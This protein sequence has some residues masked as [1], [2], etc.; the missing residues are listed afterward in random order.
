[1]NRIVLSVFAG[2][3]LC[4][5]N[6]ASGLEL[7]V[8]DYGC[9]GDGVTDDTA[10]VQAALKA[11]VTA[12]GGTVY[13][14][15]GHT[16]LI[17]GQIIVPNDS[18]L[19]PSQLPITLKGEGGAW[20]GTWS[21]STRGAATLDMRYAGPV[22]KL[23]TRGRGVLQIE[24]LAFIDNGSDSTPFIQT[25]NTTVIAIHN[26]FRGSGPGRQRSVNDVFI[27]GGMSQEM[28]GGSGAPFQGYGTVIRENYF[29]RIRRAVLGQ[30]WANGIEVTYNTISN[31]SGNLNGGAIVWQRGP[32]IP[33]SDN[34]QYG[35]II[36]NNLIEV[37]GYRYG[38]Q[39]QDGTSHNTIV[40]NSCYDAK[41]S[42]T[43]ACVY[44]APDSANNIVLMGIVGATSSIVPVQSSENNIIMEPRAMSIS[45]GGAI[46]SGTGYT[47]KGKPLASA[48][49]SDSESLARISQVPRMAGAP[50][51]LAGQRSSIQQALP[52]SLVEPGIYRIS[53]IAYPAPSGKGGAVSIECAYNEGAGEKKFLLPELNL[54]SSDA[55]SS[56]SFLVHVFRAG[57]VNVRTKIRKPLAGDVAYTLDVFV[58]KLP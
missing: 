32:V 42:L 45:A 20:D 54:A 40:G 52:F 53:V 6:A 3:L 26:S 46:N 11:A 48:N 25:T 43:I 1:M 37:A 2:A 8:L 47:V 30:E 51:H 7:N 50:F 35:N 19:L 12:G 29:S 56:G 14:S 18:K 28:G 23:D 36:E 24:N 27:L 15:P 38:I 4:F 17:L 34:G 57:S 5:C 13:F 16:Y 41:S 9:R 44:L 10:C 55:Q 33:G 21:S 58:E 39:L 31:D 49:L 22:A